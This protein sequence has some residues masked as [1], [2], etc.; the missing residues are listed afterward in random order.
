MFILDGK[1]L[2]PDVAFTR[3]GIQ[4]PANWL[5]LSSPEQREAIGITE[6][7]GEPYYDQ[8]F[9]WGY[10][11]DGA[12]IPKDHTQLVKQWIA[13]TKQ[14]AASFLSQYDWYIT[15]QSETGKAVPQVVLDYRGYVR[16]QSD[17]RE[18]MIKGTTDTDQLVTVITSDF[19][20]LFP[21][22]RGPFE[23]EPVVEDDEPTD[24]EVDSDDTT[25]II[26]LP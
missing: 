9:Y 16:T 20:G 2:S 1:S 23:P 6:A 4:Y 24:P 15:R 10:D 25:D 18:V 19:G 3:D 14:T 17:N 22:P 7:P 26:P 12:L 13:Q 11:A 21:W 8:R 5:R